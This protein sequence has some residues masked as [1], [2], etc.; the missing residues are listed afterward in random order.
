MRS[1]FLEPA[2]K[3]PISYSELAKSPPEN[4]E[5]LH[6]SGGEQVIKSVSG[7]DSSHL[8]QAAVARILP[9][10][11]LISQMRSLKGNSADLTYAVAH[12]S[13]KAKPW[14]LDM[15]TDLPVQLVGN[16][17]QFA[18]TKRYVRALIL[19]AFCKKVI[20]WVEAGRQAFIESFD[21]V[22]D[23]VV[24]VN[25]CVPRRSIRRKIP[26]KRVKL[27]FVNSGNINT[28]EH[29]LA[30]GG[31]E[32]VHAYNILKKEFPDLELVL[33]SGMSRKIEKIC[34]QLP[35]VKVIRSV[36]PWPELQEEWTSSDI[37]V[38]P[39]HSNTPSTI[40]LDAM[41]YGL[42]IVTTDVWANCEVVEDNKSGLIVEHRNSKKY[43]R[44]NILDFSS[45]DYRAS[46]YHLDEGLVMGLVSKLRTLIKDAKLREEL[47]NYGLK[48]IE[49]G[50]FSVEQRNERLKR[51]LDSCHV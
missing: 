19:S 16:D 36:I 3:L 7:H 49:G 25:W 48:Q 2:W 40:F 14:V 50:R 22:E 31:R 27:L 45:R 26:S 21:D 15:E 23:K 34:S 4:Y 10:Q 35:D 44:R 17:K 9:V 20:C 42:P 13:M 37:F 5:V 33:R 47:G 38:M 1:I 41:S 51:V 30:K 12:V 8:L 39:N 43:V 29:F 46:L 28:A 6:D 18:L 32:V 24:C 11:L